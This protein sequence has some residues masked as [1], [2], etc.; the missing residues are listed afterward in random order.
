MIVLL[1]KLSSNFPKNIGAKALEASAIAIGSR[2]GNIAIDK[3]EKKFSKPTADYKPKS[4]GDVIVSELSKNNSLTSSSSLKP[5][6]LPTQKIFYYLL[7][8]IVLI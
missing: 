8:K 6:V 7:K 5:F 4:L 1:K 3:I 2:V